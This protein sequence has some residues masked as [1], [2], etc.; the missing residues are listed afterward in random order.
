MSKEDARHKRKSTASTRSQVRRNDR[1]ADCAR[2]RLERQRANAVE[3]KV[4]RANKSAI[5]RAREDLRSRSWHDNRRN[6]LRP[7]LLEY[8]RLEDQLAEIR[9]AVA[10]RRPHRKRDRLDGAF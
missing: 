6:A 2:H 5:R 10:R 8:E 1:D 7:R 4:R 9:A 3:L